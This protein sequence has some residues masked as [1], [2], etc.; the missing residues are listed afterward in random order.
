LFAKKA[1]L[2]LTIIEN[3]DVFDTAKNQIT[4]DWLATKCQK[5]T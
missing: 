4:L 2:G 3:L 5:P 1:R